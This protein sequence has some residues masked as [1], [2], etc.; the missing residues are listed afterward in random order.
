MGVLLCQF[1]ALNLKKVCQILL[2]QFWEPLSHQA[3]LLF[4]TDH[5]GRPYGG[6]TQRGSGSGTTWEREKCHFPH[7]PVEPSLLAV[8]IQVPDT[9]VKTSWTFQPSHHETTAL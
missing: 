5:V 7:T 9:R 4:W 1:Q 2:L 3:Q 8:P 6:A